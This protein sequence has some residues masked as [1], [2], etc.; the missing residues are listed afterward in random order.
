MRYRFRC[1]NRS[2]RLCQIFTTLV[3]GNQ[4][5][6]AL[7][8]LFFATNIFFTLVYQ[9]CRP[10]SC[11]SFSPKNLLK[12]SPYLKLQPMRELSRSRSR[13]R[14]RSE[15]FSAPSA[16]F[17]LLL[18]PSHFCVAPGKETRRKKVLQGYRAHFY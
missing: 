17:S 5:P 4:Y 1:E 8:P 6:E 10:S 18:S 9:P 12:F 14:V 16:L 2:N 7:T 11:Q 13:S 3:S 15:A